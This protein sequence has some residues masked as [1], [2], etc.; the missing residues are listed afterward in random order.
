MT[1]VLTDDEI[2]QY[3]ASR[4]GVRHKPLTYFGRIRPWTRLARVK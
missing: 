4:K 2:N 1:L 3:I